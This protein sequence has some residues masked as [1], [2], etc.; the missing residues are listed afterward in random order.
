MPTGGVDGAVAA[1]K[2]SSS[3]AAA[4]KEAQS[5]AS[6]PP[7]KPPKEAAVEAAEAA[8]EAAEPMLL[9]VRATRSADAKLGFASDQRNCIKQLVAGGQAETDGLLQMG[10]EV[11]AVEGEPLAGRPLAQVLLPLPPLPFGCFCPSPWV[12]MPLLSHSRRSCRAA[13]RRMSS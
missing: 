12:L 1:A 4:A 10:D 6:A 7:S 9:R 3:K 8:A 13:R 2:A 11:I 5:T